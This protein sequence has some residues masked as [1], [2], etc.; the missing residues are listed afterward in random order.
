MFFSRRAAG[1]RAQ[2]SQTLFMRLIL[3]LSSTLFLSLL[4][5]LILTVRR[6]VRSV[7]APKS[8][9]DVR[10]VSADLFSQTITLEETSST[11]LPGRYGLVTNGSTGYL[12]LGSV[13]SRGEGLVTRKLLTEVNQDA[14][15]QAD[16]KFSG[17]YYDQP[18]QLHLPFNKVLISSP[19]GPCPGWVFP[20]DPANVN[21]ESWVIQIHGWGSS[22][23]ECLRAVPLLNRLGFTSMIVSYRNDGD[24]PSIA[25]GTSTLGLSEWRDIDAAITFARRSGARSVILMGWSMGG[26]IALQTVLRSSHSA[27]ISGVI[28]DSP[29]VDWPMVLSAQAAQNNIPRSLASLSKV[30]M[31]SPLGATI[32][33]VREPVSFAELDVLGKAE[34]LEHPILILHSADDSFVPDGAS[35]DLAKAR[36]DLVELV[37]FNGPGHTKIWNYD[38]HGWEDAITKWLARVVPDAAPNPSADSSAEAED[39]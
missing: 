9:A 24:A 21:H 10:I 28:L 4:A 25:S 26:A 7:L 23:A 35:H 22:R 27:F 38:Q 32:S 1:A 39:S 30:T 5:S 16:A 8:A 20:G 2:R 18:E 14:V 33:S 12:R 3:V 6:I 13:L 11:L 19:V 15:F 34:R 37:S 29:V 31:T 36:P 17:W